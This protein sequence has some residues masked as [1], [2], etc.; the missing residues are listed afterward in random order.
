[1]GRSENFK[2]YAADC[3]RQAEG[4]QSPEDRAILLNVALA[5]VRLAQQSQIADA[6]KRAV[7]SAVPPAAPAETPRPAA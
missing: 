2:Q 5:W 1:M 7:E 6:A 4:Q 3:M